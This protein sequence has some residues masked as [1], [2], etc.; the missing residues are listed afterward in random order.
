MDLGAGVA[1]RIAL[2]TGGGSGIGLAIATRLAEHGAKVWIAGRRL[3]VLK[4]AAA[5]IA[6]DVRTAQL[7]VRDA[8]NCSSLID[9]IAD[10]DGIVDILV[11]NAGNYIKAPLAQTTDADFDD[12]Q[13]THVDGAFAL[14]RACAGPM[15]EKG[16][17]RVVFIASMTALFGLPDV[18]AYSAAKAAIV[19][20]TRSLAAELGPVGI[21]V[22]AVAP[23]WIESDYM[24]RTLD[25]NPERKRKILSRTPLGRFGHP[26]DI[27]NAVTFLCSD[28]ASFITGVVLP[29]DGGASIGF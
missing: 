14:T 29:V 1:G 5:A 20:L 9:R 10:E 25:A 6:Q 24:L 11:N 7:D 12:I 3:E 13:R 15:G 21:N 27:G 4:E 26:K 8:T 18:V 23:G 16:R 19:G 2:V 22:N 17:G 28:H